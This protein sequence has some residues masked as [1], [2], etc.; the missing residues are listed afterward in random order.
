MADIYMYMNV[1]YVKY[2]ASESGEWIRRCKARA[3]VPV[4]G[5]GRFLGEREI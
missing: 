3:V 2:V 1:I 4:G 5:K